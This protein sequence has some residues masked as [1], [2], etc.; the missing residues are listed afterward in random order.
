MQL[1]R[2]K[3][4][5]LMITINK[6]DEA[7]YKALKTLDIK[8]NAF[9]LFYAIAEGKAYSQK[10]ICDEWSIPRTTLNTIVQ[11]YIKKGYI[12]FIPTGHKEKEIILTDTGKKFVKEALSPVFAAEEKAIEPF[13]QTMLVEQMENIAE[14]IQTEFSKFKKHKWGIYYG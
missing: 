2:E 12:K 4:R 13:L 9:V 5:R 3:I 6:I 10:K 7:Y 14:Q 11:E 8:D 1:N